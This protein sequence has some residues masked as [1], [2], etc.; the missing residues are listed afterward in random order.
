MDEVIKETWTKLKEKRIAEI[1]AEPK[2]APNL[3]GPYNPKWASNNKPDGPWVCHQQKVY[4]A[5]LEAAK[6]HTK[7]AN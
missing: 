7:K 3:Q 6:A 1:M 2:D 5:A 4:D